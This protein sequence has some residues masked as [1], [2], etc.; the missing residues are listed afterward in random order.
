MWA[1]RTHWWTSHQCHPA[2]W[3]G[4]WCLPLVPLGVVQVALVILLRAEAEGRGPLEVRAEAVPFLERVH[5][6]HRLDQKRQPAVWRRPPAEVGD[7]L[8]FR[9]RLPFPPRPPQL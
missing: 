4:V 3:F 1:Y 2:A 5:T 8:L 6:P 7:L 9:E